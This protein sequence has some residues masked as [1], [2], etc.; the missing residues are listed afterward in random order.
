L[1]YVE[2]VGLNTVRPLL[3]A[4]NA[5]CIPP[6]LKHADGSVEGTDIGGFALGQGLGLQ[7]GYQE[8]RRLLSKGDL[9]ILTSDGLVEAS[10]ARGEMFGFARLEQALRS[11]PVSSAAALLEHL[12]E[13]LAAHVGQ[14]EPH[15]DITIV[16]GRV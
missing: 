4:V 6:Y 1:C 5:G 14:A 16:V 2:L 9:I 3:K 7:G 11:G 13:V 12:K 10:N 8:I 15:D